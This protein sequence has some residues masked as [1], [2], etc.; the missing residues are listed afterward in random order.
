MSWEDTKHTNVNMM[1]WKRYE[2]CLLSAM[3]HGKF[4]QKAANIEPFLLGIFAIPLGSQIPFINRLTIYTLYSRFYLPMESQMCVTCLLIKHVDLFLLCYRLL[5]VDVDPLLITPP[6]H[7]LD[8]HF[9]RWG[10]STNTKQHLIP[11]G[12]PI[13]QKKHLQGSYIFTARSRS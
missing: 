8:Q 9:N 11:Q 3:V 4:I 2:S 13:K 10:I 1:V 12:L 5:I 6:P 7:Q